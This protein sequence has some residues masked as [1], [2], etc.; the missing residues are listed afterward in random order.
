MP[1][2]GVTARSRSEQLVR[3]SASSVMRKLS[4]V[5]IGSSFAKRSASLGSLQL[6]K[7]KGGSATGSSGGDKISRTS[8]GTRTAKPA[9]TQ[10]WHCAQP[11]SPVLSPITDQAERCGSPSSSR[12]AHQGEAAGHSGPRADVD[13][14]GSGSERHGT[15]HAKRGICVPPAD[16]P[17]PAPDQAEEERT[18]AAAPARTCEPSVTSPASFLDRRS[19]RP[20]LQRSTFSQASAEPKKGC[21]PPPLGPGH[22]LDHGQRQDNTKTAFPSQGTLLGKLAKVRVKHREAVAEGIRSFFR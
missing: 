4:V 12:Q 13:S 5:G 21:S 19:S 2:P 8:E 20:S 6:Q 1:F 14:V 11:A 9:V 3:A 15:Q 7:E 17:P 22:S 10:Q 18:E 16:V